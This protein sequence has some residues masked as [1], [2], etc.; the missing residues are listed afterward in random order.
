V[1]SLLLTKGL[2][3]IVSFNPMAC[4]LVFFIITNP[5][6]VHLIY[7]TGSFNKTANIAI[8]SIAIVAVVFLV[9]YFL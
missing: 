3:S 2:V 9:M 5:L 7:K 4:F 1:L 6:I 8:R